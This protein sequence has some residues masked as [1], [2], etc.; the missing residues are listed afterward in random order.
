MIEKQKEGLR[1]LLGAP[2]G[3]CAGVDRAIDIVEKAL[4]IFGAPIYVRHEIVHNKHVVQRLQDRGV[5]FVED[6]SEAPDGAVLIFSAHGVSKAVRQEAARRPIRLI[7]ATCPLVTKVHLEVHRLEKKGYEVLLIGHFGHVEVQGTMGQL[8][9]GKIRLVQT[10]EDAETVTVTDP[11]K[12]AYVTQTTLSLDETE[13]IVEV[14]KRR[15]PNLKA[16]AKND[17]C[18]ATQNRQNTIKSMIRE[19]DLLLVIGSKNSSNSN[20]LVEVGRLHG[21]GGYLIDHPEEMQPEWFEGVRA[22]G[23]TAGASAPE[24]LVQ[25]TV[26]YLLKEYGGKVESFV[27]KEEKV[28]FPMPKDLFDI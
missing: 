25:A 3:F 28:S 10:P 14:L 17:I 27:Y 7:D 18:Y 24:D 26:D 19:I 8:P 11:D 23:L 16:P 6:V 13:S 5:R 15:F 20:R 2:R 21:V 12:V 1:I 22:V 4:E 9:A